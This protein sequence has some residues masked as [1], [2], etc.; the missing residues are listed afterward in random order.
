MPRA[1]QD[2]PGHACICYSRAGDGRS[3]SFREGADEVVLRIEPRLV[4]SNSMAIHR[5]A[6]AGAGLAVLSH[7]L[8]EPDIEAGRLVKLMPDFPPTRLPINVV[9]PS[10]RNIP[11]RVT[12][13][14]DFLVQAVRDDVSMASSAPLSSGSAF[15]NKGEGSLSKL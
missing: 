7:I 6:L 11:L 8:V 9:Y 4:A 14:L 12:T 2:I 1:P 15:V 10:R 5:A 3:W 13:V